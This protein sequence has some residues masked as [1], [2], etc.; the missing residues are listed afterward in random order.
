LPTSAVAEMLSATT[1][2]TTQM[3][4]LQAD[5]AM[6]CLTEFGVMKFLD[7]VIG[8]AWGA[9]LALPLSLI[10]L[11][12]LPT[13]LLVALPIY[14]SLPLICTFR[15]R[16]G[17]LVGA[18]LWPMAVWANESAP[19]SVHSQRFRIV[20]ENSRGDKLGSGVWELQTV[21]SGSN[22]NTKETGWR[23]EAFEIFDP[24]GN[25]YFVTR[26]GLNPK[27]T[28]THYPEGWTQS[29][30]RS[31]VQAHESWIAHLNKIGLRIKL[32]YHDQPRILVATDKGWRSP[33]NGEL[34]ARELSVYLEVTELPLTTG[35][36]A[37]E[38]WII[39]ATR[40]HPVMKIDR[41]I[42]DNRPWPWPR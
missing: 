32:K 8:L 28:A 29:S 11:V 9:V 4:S 2:N 1:V 38:P 12:T 36:L 31:G 33:G 34:N 30:P 17:V 13:S 6:A 21:W 14:F 23:G 15:G 16:P 22:S 18:L 24:A 25:R 10:S 41:F 20:V 37:K 27:I 5:D 39:E 40:N 3:I 42:F 19:Q 26:N 7:F 35:F